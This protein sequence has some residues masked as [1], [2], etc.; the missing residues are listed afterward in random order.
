MENN[1]IQ[2]IDNSGLEETKANVLKEK[3]LHYFDLASE[4][5][6]RA[7]D[8][9]V[10]DESQTA[11]MQMAKVGR[12]ELSDKRIAVEKT[13][14]ELKEQSL[15]EGKA[16]DGIANVLK[17]LIIP[18]EDHLKKQ[19]CFIELKQKAEEERIRLEIEKKKLEELREKERKETEERERIRVENEK[20]KAEAERR[21]REIQAERQKQAD[22]LSK[23]K[24][25]AERREREIQQKADD[26]KKKH[27]E[28]INKQKAELQKKLSELIT[29]PKC[30]HNFEKN[31]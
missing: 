31:T 17:G 23:Q 12:K 9:V 14:K 8:I 26:E 30:G 24:A 13:R 4:W 28:E 22:I 20:L 21:E 15:R 10:T 3:F 16:I 2:I 18:I 29:C 19:E 1:L 5:E 27:Q 7:K 25:E 11:L 6:K